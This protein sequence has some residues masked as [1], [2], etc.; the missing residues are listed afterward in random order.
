VITS[1]TWRRNRQSLSILLL[2]WVIAVSGADVHPNQFVRTWLSDDGLPENIVTGVVQ[3]PDGFLWVSTPSGLARFDGIHFEVYSHTNF[4]GVPNPFVRA[5]AVSR[6]GGLWLAMDRG[7]V[8]NV[9]AGVAHVFTRF[10]G[11][12]SLH[13][14][15]AVED[16]AGALWIGYSNGSLYRL[17]AGKATDYSE[18]DG[19]P[20]GEFCSLAKDS[21]GVIWIARG[22]QLGVWRNERFQL[23]Q[24]TGSALTGIAA[25]RAGGV[26]VC[27]DAMLMY[28]D[29]SGH[30]FERGAFKPE[31]S[32]L[33][34]PVLLEDSSGAVWI[35]TSTSGLIRFDG[36]DFEQIP[37][38]HYEILSLTEDHEGNLWVGT[39]GGGLNR[40]RP[41]ALQLEGA[42]AG[43]IFPIVQSLCED[44]QG[45]IWAAAQNGL[46]ARRSVAGW[47]IVS[48]NAG[49][50]GGAV[51]CVAASPDGTVWIGTQD[52]GLYQWQDGRF[53]PFESSEGISNSVVH[54]LIVGKTGEVWI[55]FG[56]RPLNRFVLRLRNGQSRLMPLP[57]GMKNIGAMAF[58]AQGD[59]WLATLAGNLLRFREYNFF[60]ETLHIGP[61]RLRIRCLHA[62]P[63]GSLWIGYEDSGLGRLKDGRFALITTAQGLA[64]NHITQIV[65]DGSGSLWFGANCG[66]FRVMQQELEEVAEG[67]ASTVMSF[68][69]GADEGLPNLEA[70]LGQSPDV[71]RSRDGRLWFPMRTGLAIVSPD[72]LRDPAEPPPVLLDRVTVDGKVMAEYRGTMPVH[73]DPAVIN[74]HAP[75]ASLRLAPSHRRVDFDF[76][77]L[78]FSAPETVNFRYRLE[79]LDKDWIDGRTHRRASYSRLSPGNYRFR[80]QASSDGR[81]WEEPGAALALNA[82]PYLQE[83]L[84]FRAV[85][86]GLVLFLVAAVVQWVVSL[87][88][89]RKVERLER[90]GALDRERARIAQDLHDD[91]GAGLAQVG[92]LSSIIQQ[93]ATSSERTQKHLRQITNTSQEMVGALD[94][95]VWAINPKHDSVTS[96]SDYFCGYAQELF[97]PTK[98]RCRLDI[99][100]DLPSDT[101]DAH[102]RHSFFLAFKEALT[103]VIR[104]S[105]AAEVWILISADAHNLLVVVEDNGKGFAARPA[106]VGADGLGNMSRRMT[107]LGG[108]CEIQSVP[109]SGTRVRFVLPLG[110]N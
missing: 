48:T 74:L 11:L 92:L 110:E 32:I 57:Q 45:N 17:Q 100:K 13:T 27:A 16:D 59:L 64:D 23:V 14:V 25:R 82:T 56:A 26:W 7:P 6:G 69:H 8:V 103:N 68:L 63:D 54:A 96:L 19:L 31:H 91:L 35:G 41:R 60:D 28:C 71:L 90:L 18:M 44:G 79:G 33:K 2:I 89:Q 51:S 38:M 106:G 102:R 66:I 24:K 76:A 29:E 99:A 72:R 46:L 105:Q 30:L 21:R 97:Q 87:Q 94:E 55:S 83:T 5:L 10:D 65:E 34:P 93:S 36:K 1:V 108:R 4:P 61:K 107:Q 78:S 80:V 40:V 12:P 62:T 58:D 67:R 81:V 15:I 84:W 50:P 109:D 39:G 85:V 22:G 101:L 49:W 88:H 47:S 70:N 42:E 3:T 53:N 9:A 86:L 98:I 77:A 43:L 20:A 104:H 73:D 37:K 52:H 95:I 75:D